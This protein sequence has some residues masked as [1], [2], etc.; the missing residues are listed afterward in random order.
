M[1][2]SI[3]MPTP[4][5]AIENLRIYFSTRAGDVKAVDGVT[6]TI[7][8]GE[9]VGLV[10]ESGSG[11]SVTAR[12]V[13]RLVPSPPGRHVDGQVRFRGQDLYELSAGEMQDLRGGRIAMIFQDPMT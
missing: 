3:T 13:M 7:A 12:S 9:V 2:D 10:G 1:T 11:K 5:L 6:L 8:P 4:V